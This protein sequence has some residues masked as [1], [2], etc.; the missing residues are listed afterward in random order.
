MDR[1]KAAQTSGVSKPGLNSIAGG[2][3]YVCGN[4]DQGF[5]GRFLIKSHPRNKIKLQIQLDIK[6]QSFG[7]V[8]FFVSGSML[9]GDTSSGFSKTYAH[10]FFTYTPKEL[11]ET[12]F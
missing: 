12:Q 8:S 5:D 7:V 11:C 10:L 3:Q 2:A 4:S 9:S 6:T 1:E